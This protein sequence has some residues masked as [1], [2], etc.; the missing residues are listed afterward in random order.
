M[1]LYIKPNLEVS[2]FDT[3]DSVMVSSTGTYVDATSQANYLEENGLLL[4]STVG[5]SGQ[6]A[7]GAFFFE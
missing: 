4:K 2:Y 3:Q 6:V 7:A 1:K 5:K